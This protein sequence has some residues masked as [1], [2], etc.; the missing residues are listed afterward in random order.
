[1]YKKLLHIAIVIIAVISFAWSQFGGH[2]YTKSQISDVS[3]DPEAFYTVEHV[4]DGDTIS[5][6]IDKTV[7]KVRLLGINTPESVD[8]RKGIECY[9]PEA[10]MYLKETLHNHNVRLEVNPDRELKD[11][12][13]RYLLYVY[14]DDGLFV[15][16]DLIEK[17]YAHEYTYGKAYMYQKEFRAAEGTAQSAKLGLWGVCK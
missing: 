14:R 6:L 5:V 7:I 17:G 3:I 10:S 2:S 4:V 8:P 15:N 13:G 16:K 1:M 12:Y 11:K 9:G